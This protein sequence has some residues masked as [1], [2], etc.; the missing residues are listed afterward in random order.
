MAGTLLDKVV[1]RLEY[2]S[3]MEQCGYTVGTQKHE[4]M[5]G[6]AVLGISNLIK[7]F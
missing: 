6:E 2:I 5:L 3:M 7:Q 1:K 4:K